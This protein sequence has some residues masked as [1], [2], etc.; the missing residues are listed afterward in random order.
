[1]MVPPADL[2]FIEHRF[3][4]AAE[5]VTEAYADSGDSLHTP[6]GLTDSNPSLLIEATER[7][8][9]ILHGLPVNGIAQ[10]PQSAPDLSETRDI[11]ALGEYG[12][13][14]LSDLAQWTKALQLAGPYRELRQT[15]FALALWIGERGGELSNLEPLVDALAFLAN[16]IHAPK[17]LEQLFLDA[18]RILESV[19]PAIAQDLD[20]SNPGRPWRVLLLNQAIIATRSHQPQLMEQAFTTLVETLP[21][22]AAGFFREGMEQ[23]EALNYPPPVRK[24]MERYF[25]LWC[26]SGTLH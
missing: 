22:D 8:L 7:L 21:E 11:H 23:M 19:S 24:V 12:I 26:S 20:R 5:A 15:L 25:E 2:V 1:M 4:S 9:V 16:S 6:A 17:E 18:T 3:R 10:N 14:L 13:R